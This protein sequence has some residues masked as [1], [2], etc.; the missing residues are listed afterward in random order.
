[1]KR[2]QPLFEARPPERYTI[3]HSKVFLITF[4]AFAPPLC[5]SQQLAA[6]IALDAPPTVTAS[7]VAT[8]PQ[9]TAVTTPGWETKVDRF[10]DL[11]TFNYGS[12]YRSTFDTNGA[13]TFDQGQQHLVADGKFKFDEQGRYGIGFHLSSGRYF[14]WSYADFIGGG[15]HQFIQ[16]A[17]ATMTP[18]Q[19]YIFN[20]LPATPGFYNSGGGQM[21][22]RQLFLQVEPIR[23]IE[24]QYGGFAINHGVNSEATSYD[25]DGYM[26]G[27]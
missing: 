1:M 5:F 11:D 25:D 21:Y 3:N 18:Y 2:F 8:A 19:L 24:F 23:G 13:H 20:I 7:V 6:N 10:L 12:R 15:Q 9:P 26:S 17:E 16:N 4:L 27:E 14:N 22:I